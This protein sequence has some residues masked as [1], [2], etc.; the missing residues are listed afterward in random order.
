VTCVSHF[1]R[2]KPQSIWS[3]IG[4]DGRR[5]PSFLPPSN[6]PDKIQQPSSAKH[7][8]LLQQRLVHMCAAVGP[9]NLYLKPYV[10]HPDRNLH[11]A[12]L[13]KLGDSAN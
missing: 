13:S 3:G 10:T 8:V 4:A 6:L 2:I 11:M 1:L 5:A 9:I 12:D 7:N